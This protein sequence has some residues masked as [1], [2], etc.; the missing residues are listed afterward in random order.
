[1]VS[2]I[3]GQPVVH[4]VSQMLHDRPRKRLGF[5]HV[6]VHFGIQVL[7]RDHKQ[8]LLLEEQCTTIYLP[9]EDRLSKYRQ[10]GGRSHDS[11]NIVLILAVATVAVLA[12]VALFAATR[13]DAIRVERSVTIN[14]ASG[15]DLFTPQRLPQL[16]ELGAP[17]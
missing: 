9:G 7:G 15:K 6:H 1:M 4:K 14:A 3:C 10:G 13:P 8:P 2:S 16:A 12:I 5:F 11:E 17:G